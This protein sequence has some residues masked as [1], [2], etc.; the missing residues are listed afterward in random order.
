MTVFSEEEG[1]RRSGR[2]GRSSA[3]LSRT[4]IFYFCIIFIC[5]QV[6]LCSA[7]HESIA[8][9]SWPLARK[10]GSSST[11]PFAAAS[12][13]PLASDNSDDK[14]IIHTGPNPLHN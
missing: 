13:S 7:N 14:R 11:V 3:A 2:S 10:L 6:C 9:F 4:A 1:V 12:P 5:V 8:P